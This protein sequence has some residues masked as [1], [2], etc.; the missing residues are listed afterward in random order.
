MTFSTNVGPYTYKWYKNGVAI[1][2]ANSN[3]AYTATSAGTYFVML[4]DA[5][6]C[7]VSSI[8]RTVT[9]ECC[10]RCESDSVGK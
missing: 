6:G 1:A 3:A 4:T 8:V 7:A 9:N 10:S 2:G 5:A